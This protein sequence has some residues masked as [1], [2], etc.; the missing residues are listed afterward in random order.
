ME[1]IKMYNFYDKKSK[2]F[3]T[4]FFVY[5]EV[6]AKRHFIMA[7]NRDGT[8]MNKFKDDYDL[9]Y[10]A[11]FNINNGDI[12]LGEN[13]LPKLVMEGKDVAQAIKEKGNE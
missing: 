6:G 7:I 10:I 12:I 5:D 8:L 4:P 2:R 13:N 1:M 11:D 9:Y 3:D